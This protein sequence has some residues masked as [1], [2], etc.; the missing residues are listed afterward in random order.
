M[1]IH[2][3]GSAEIEA[4]K[5]RLSTAKKYAVSASSSVKSAQA[6]FDAAKAVLGEANNEVKEAAASLK[7]AEE[8]WNL[9]IIDGDESPKK[10][11]KLC[12]DRAEYIEISGCGNDGTN[13]VYGRIGYH[14]GAPQFMKWGHILQ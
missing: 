1:P 2:S 5:A 3:A 13:G 11:R 12:F 9:I 8:K 6:A 10:K 4:A 14:A 7:A